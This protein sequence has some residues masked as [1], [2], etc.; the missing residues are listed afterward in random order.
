MTLQEIFATAEHTIRDL[1]EH[2]DQSLIPKV[3]ELQRLVRADT[4][5]ERDQVA[6]ATV[7]SH[8]ASLISSD[9]YTQQLLSRFEQYL[10]VIEQRTRA[11][12]D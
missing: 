5:E 7:R 9:D 3:S 10:D 11:L 8:S 4:R 1:S 2:L 6:D 12:V